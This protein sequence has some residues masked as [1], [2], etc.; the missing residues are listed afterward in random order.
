MNKWLRRHEERLTARGAVLRLGKAWRI[1]EPA[2]RPA[3]FE[4]LTEERDA[5]T[6]NKNKRCKVRE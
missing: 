6:R 3:L 4:I 1:I 5:V 2:F